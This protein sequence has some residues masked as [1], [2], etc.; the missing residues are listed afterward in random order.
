MV[1]A[2]GI[3][4]IG[5]RVRRRD[6]ISAG[7]GSDFFDSHFMCFGAGLFFPFLFSHFFSAGIQSFYDNSVL[8][9]YLGQNYLSFL[10]AVP[11]EISDIHKCFCQC[12]LRFF[13]LFL[14]KVLAAFFCHRLNGSRNYRYDISIRSLF[15]T[16]VV[17]LY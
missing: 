11:M 2:M 16:S 7:K 1:L 15:Q 8:F 9:T 14:L 10:H 13:H 17:Y 6:D 4:R 3:R 12:S 5:K